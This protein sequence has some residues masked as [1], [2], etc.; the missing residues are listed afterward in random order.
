MNPSAALKSLAAAIAAAFAIGIA[1]VTAQAHGGLAANSISPAQV[2]KIVAGIQV[3]R[4]LNFK[5]K[6]PITYITPDAVA[7]R[8]TADVNNAKDKESIRL[9]SES[10]VMLGLYPPNVDLAGATIAM[11]QGQLGG[12]YDF[13]RK[14]L[15]IVE[16]PPAKGA[17]ISNEEKIETEDVIA[18]ELTHALQDQNFKIAKPLDNSG[19]DDDRT[20]A[21]R[22]VVEG[23]ATLAGFGFI[24]GRMDDQVLDAFVK[25]IPEME[26]QFAERTR[27]VPLG[28]R[29]PFIFQY[30]QGARFVAE[31]Y[32]RDGWPGV[33]ALYAHPPQSTQQILNPWMYFDRPAPVPQVHVVGYEKVLKDW[34]KSD[35]SA[36]GELML[37]VIIEAT[38][39]KDSAYVAIAN[40]WA[41]DSMVILTKG[42]SVTVLWMIA[43]TNEESAQ[44]FAD[45]YGDALDKIDGAHAAHRVERNGRTAL[46]MVGDGAIRFH[47]F[48]AEVWK[49]STVS[50]SANPRPPG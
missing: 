24:A 10:G 5:S 17:V 35:E 36:A 9:A 31:A 47:E 39:G 33:N 29:E 19:Q 30:M 22:A 43:F 40:A 26:K 7:K 50:S 11:L 25:H 8:M 37:R 45:A 4:G 1:L 16:S 32:H 38:L 12:F 13:R 28:I 44:S 21:L 48:L 46:V 20:A 3:L 18:H 27:D 49:Q 14:D 23:D 42:S 2:R 15:A 6:I 41:G 34:K